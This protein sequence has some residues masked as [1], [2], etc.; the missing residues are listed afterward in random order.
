MGPGHFCARPS[1]CGVGGRKARGRGPPRLPEGS[2]AA[3]RRAPAAVA[4]PFTRPLAAASRG[5]RCPAP[6]LGARPGRGSRPLLRGGGRPG[7]PGP[8]AALCG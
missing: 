2:S 8:A 6:G 3:P 5:S 1:R 7:G 4:A